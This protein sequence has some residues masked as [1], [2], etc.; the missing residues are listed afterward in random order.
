MHR[1]VLQ[2]AGERLL[3]LP[4]LG[5]CLAQL[6]EVGS[7]E[8]A[9]RGDH[10]MDVSVTAMGV[11]SGVFVSSPAEALALLRLQLGHRVAGPG[12]EVAPWFGVGTGAHHETVEVAPFFARLLQLLVHFVL[13]Q[14]VV[15][16]IK[17]VAVLPLA[18]IVGTL[19]VVAGAALSV[20]DVSGVGGF[21][22]SGARASAGHVSP[23]RCRAPLE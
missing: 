3:T 22:D 7:V 15:L 5:S 6:L 12:F 18:G 9:I 2:L 4:S 10:H 11:V 23:P 17:G 20:T 16:F 21:D 19:G 13:A 1:V 14:R 8:L